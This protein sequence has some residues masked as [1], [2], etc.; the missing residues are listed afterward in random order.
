MDLPDSQT[1]SG[2]STGAGVVAGVALVVPSLDSRI[3]PWRPV[4]KQLTPGTILVLPTLLPSWAPAVWGALAVVTDS[5][6]ALS[7]GA[8][9]A[10]QASI[11]R[12]ARNAHWNLV[13]VRPGSTCRL[14]SA[15]WCSPCAEHT[16]K[17]LSNFSVRSGFGPCAPKPDAIP[18]SRT[19][20]P[21]L[22]PKEPTWRRHRRPDPAVSRSFRVSAPD[23]SLGTFV[24]YF[25][26]GLSYLGMLTLLEHYLAQNVALGDVWAGLSPGF[27]TGGIT[28]AMFLL[29]IDER[30]LGRA[31]PIADLVDGRAAR[32]TRW[33]RWRKRGLAP[34]LWNG[35]MLTNLVAMVIIIIGYRA[36]FSPRPYPAVKELSSAKPPRR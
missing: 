32:W 35:L 3:R 15:W 25:V 26:D 36:R 29:R 6:G 9:L 10:R 27:L 1:L 18:V 17:I 22:P 24:P 8:I 34:G 12:C 30:S 14:V 23:L 2:T 33:W 21:E 16:H 7:H 13:L 28:F 5:G 31:T 11:P 19:G 4:M 20:R